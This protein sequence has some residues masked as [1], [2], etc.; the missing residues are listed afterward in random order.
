VWQRV[1]HEYQAMRAASRGRFIVVARDKGCYRSDEFITEGGAIGRRSEP[2]FGV[3]RKRR[4]L[5][6][7]SP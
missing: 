1:C 7:S 3:Q 6:F 4:Q 5:F 2:D